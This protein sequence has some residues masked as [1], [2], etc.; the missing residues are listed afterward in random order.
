VLPCCK[1][2]VLLPKDPARSFF[3]HGRRPIIFRQLSFYGSSGEIDRR[4]KLAEA[5]QRRAA[6]GPAR[7]TLLFVSAQQIRRHQ[8]VRG[9]RLL[10]VLEQ[11]VYF[12]QCECVNFAKRPPGGSG[13]VAVEK[14]PL[15]YT[16]TGVGSPEAAF[17]R[18]ET[19]R[20]ALNSAPKS[21]SVSP[22]SICSGERS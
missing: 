19:S 4:G 7:I 15:R 2:L 13:D 14:R 21:S 6:A 10:P 22:F 8:H 11:I 18:P 17:F 12:P 16:A 3:S 20:T 5:W 9:R 1:S